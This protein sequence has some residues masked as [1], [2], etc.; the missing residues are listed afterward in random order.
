MTPRQHSVIIKRIVFVTSLDD[1]RPQCSPTDN[2]RL[3]GSK[4][5]VKWSILED[6]PEHE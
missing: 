3:T 5:A 1:C 2:K 6:L 4:H